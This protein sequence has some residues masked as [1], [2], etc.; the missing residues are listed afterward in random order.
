MKLERVGKKLKNKRMYCTVAACL[1]FVFCIQCANGQKIRFLDQTP[2]PAVLHALDKIKTKSIQINANRALNLLHNQGYLS[3][4]VHQ[5]IF[6]SLKNQSYIDI[7]LGEQYQ[8]EKIQITHAP[9]LFKEGNS[10]IS[11][12]N[13]WKKNLSPRLK[14][15]HIASPEEWS[16]WKE[17]IITY[18]E[19]NG[20]PFVQVWLDSIQIENGNITGVLQV[21]PNRSFY[22]DSVL[23]KGNAKINQTYIRRYLNLSPGDPYN[24]SVVRELDQRIDEI[25]FIKREKPSEIIFTEK[26]SKA[27]LYLNKKKANVFNG[28]LGFLP[29]N[30]TGKLLITGD[31][32]LKLLNS[33]GS[34][35]K[36]AANWKKLQPQTQN[37]DVAISYPYALDLPVGLEGTFNLYKR[38]TSFITISGKL[39]LAYLM[40]AGNQIS[41]FYS[42]TQSN[43]LQ[44][45][46][47]SDLA[48]ISINNYGLNLIWQ[49]L[50]Y[51]FN[52]RKGIDLFAE[53]AVGTK[54][55]TIVY[56]QNDVQKDST[57]RTSQITETTWLKTYIPLF[58]RAAIGISVK[59]A[60]IINK[61]I[62]TN[63]LLR[64]GGLH[65]LKGFDEESIF[66]SAHTIGYIEVKYV[67][68]RNSSAFIFFN[69][70]YY[71]N[72]ADS[73]AIYGYPYGFGVGGLF[74]TKAGIFQ[75][76]Y[77][78]GRNLYRQ[79][80]V[81]RDSKLLF[82]SGKIHFGFVSFF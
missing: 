32:Q 24:E 46:P 17:E 1:I 57:Q 73:V 21:Q 10:P 66:T 16:L 27:Q 36:I 35:E 78:L 51:R 52:P 42:R 60:R 13:S 7:L 53:A 22:I 65:S 8:F 63:E 23:L 49:K 25:P 4:Y 31:I 61:Q 14:N 70:A 39:G 45:E 28:I 62:Y 68:E 20:H 75:I 2:E 19:N 9:Y 15:N 48:G 30:Q 33:L 47:T 71:Q 77:A 3:A 38:D 40:N 11:K 59:D 80:D 56:T 76:N 34:G 69:A 44:R 43:I 54:N 41:A 18:Y 12:N 55:S 72:R 29:D 50:D 64:I 79:G 74:E 67:L 82:R 26:G 37:L 81:W 6:D 58:S 5:I